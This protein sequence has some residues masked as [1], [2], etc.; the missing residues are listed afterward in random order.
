M[1]R[2][3]Q[4][5]VLEIVA[6]WRLAFIA[7][8]LLFATGAYAQ[9]GWEKENEGEIKDVQYEIIVNKKVTLPRASRNFEKVPPRPFEP[10]EPAI[11]YEARNFRFA[12]PDFKPVIRPL[13]L[14]AEELPKIYGNYLSTGFGNYNSFF[15]EGSLTTK[16]DK[17]RYLGAHIYHRSFGNGPIAEKNSASSTL[18][19]QL[20][21]KATGKV[22]T[23]SGEGN[24]E[25][26]GTYFYGYNPVTEIDRD[27]IRQ[28]FDIYS[29][30]AGIE[31][32]KVGDFN[33]TLKSGYSYLMDHYN[34]REG[35]FA[36][37]FASAYHINETDRVI[38]TADYFNISRTDLNFST[39]PRHLFKVKPAYRFTAIQDL[40]LTIGA[41][42][43]FQND[44]YAGSKDFHLY[45]DVKAQYSLSP[46][47]ELYGAITG[48][49]D[50]VT[51]HTI[52]AEN[53][54]VKT[55]QPF[56]HTNRLEL[57]GGISGKV[58]KKV[59]FG[60]GFSIAELKNLYNYINRPDSLNPSGTAIGTAADRMIV[61]YE[62]NTK[63][64][65]PYAELSYSHAEA[66]RFSLRGDLFAYSTTDLPNTYN[67]PTWKVNA[68][69]RTNLYEKIS[70][71]AGILAQGGLK[72][73]EVMSSQP[74]KYFDLDP[75]IDVNAK[76]RYFLSK[77][78]SAFVQMNNLLSTSYPIY[79]NYQARGFQVLAGVSWSF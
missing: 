75:A 33:Y 18:A 55:D 7:L 41:N 19:L 58:G 78:F 57:K 44:Q 12:T 61:A 39:D 24:L 23:F 43:V 62:S 72:A 31:N 73:K 35:E 59:A 25:N 47:V 5:S 66:F 76:A 14:K 36:L 49:I 27:R 56:Y 28:T 34:A 9:E 79:L 15:V 64:V 63:R 52:S 10:I 29:V 38:F 1:R 53:L 11:R 30:R 37:Q 40:V 3:N 13:K 68:S 70:L 77:Q 65:N 32:T 74:D 20:F 2:P 50:K 51:L 21:G 22:I 54:W 60:V 4:H 48:D 26:R 71:E 46:S 6:S 67:R 42:A 45:P 69:V 8:G 16:R 17:S